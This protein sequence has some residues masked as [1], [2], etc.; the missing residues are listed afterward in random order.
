MPVVIP[1]TYGAV[2]NGVADD[3]PA[4][5]AALTALASTTGIDGVRTLQL[6]RGK[7]YLTNQTINVSPTASNSLKI[8]G[9]GVL[10]DGSTIIAGPSLP[11]GAPVVRVQAGTGID[12]IV[13]VHLEAFRI[14]P[15][16]SE[17][18]FNSDHTGL[19]IFGSTDSLKKNVISEVHIGKFETGLKFTDT[20]LWLVSNSCVW[21]EGVPNAR[22]VVLEATDTGK[23]CGD[24]DFF[25]S[26]FVVDRGL[27]NSQTRCVSIRGD[28]G[29]I[30]GLGFSETIFYHGDQGMVIEAVNGSYI[31]DIW[32]NPRCQFDGLLNTYGAY[33]GIFA[34]AVGTGSFIDNLNV[35]GTYF[36]G[37]P[38]SLNVIDIRAEDGGQIRHVSI[39]HN[40]I[41]D[42]SGGALHLK[43]ATAAVVMGNRLHNIG[44]LE[45]SLYTM[46]GF[47]NTKYF[48]ATGNTALKADAGA[49]LGINIDANC[50][51][52]SVTGNR[53]YGAVSVANIQNSTTPTTPTA[54]PNHRIV[55]SNA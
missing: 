33:R 41:G 50:D 39:T 36:R 22:A 14:D 24:I 5:Q 18:V 13:D 37:Y 3:G 11:A 2:G 44:N 52:F 47:E 30:T 25:Q 19:Q 29:G 7:R 43:G 53:F 16:E 10:L 28:K 38:S 8:V 6:G 26:Q 27:E 12:S 55:A 35:S 9:A 42:A 31:N 49:Y 54:D 48:T 46:I 51:Y 21:A 45:S 40:W 15:Y 17:G 23:T 1:E 32:I 34:T 4:L 20:R